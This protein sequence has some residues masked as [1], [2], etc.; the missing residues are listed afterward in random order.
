MLDVSNVSVI[1]GKV[2]LFDNLYL[3]MHE[4]EKLTLSG[5]S[6]SGKSTLLRC[7]IGFAPFSGAIHIDSEPLNTHTVWRLRRKVAYVD[8][9]PDLGPGQVREALKRPFSYKANHAVN[10]D[11]HRVDSLF[12]RFLLPQSLQSKE[13]RTLSGGEK[14]RVALIA[15]LL[16]KRPLLLLDEAASA[17]DANSKHQVREYLREQSELT[18]LSVSHDTRDFTL[19]NSVFNI[20]ALKKEEAR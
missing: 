1:F 19:S 16:L 2:T 12:E 9:E 17:L 13:V 3:S 15:A 10:F 7:I 20:E 5:P 4:G 14:Q 6:G 8:Q 18:I 11:P